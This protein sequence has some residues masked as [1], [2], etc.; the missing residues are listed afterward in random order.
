MV[1][2]IIIYLYR[3]VQ[4]FDDGKFDEFDEWLAICQ[5]FF[6]LTFLLIVSPIEARQSFP[7]KLL[8]Y[9][10]CSTVTMYIRT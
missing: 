2:I 10:V 8:L 7:V 6:L 5:S 9:M 3:I 4:K 1:I